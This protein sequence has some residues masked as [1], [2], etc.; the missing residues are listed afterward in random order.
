M[1]RRILFLLLGCLLMTSQIYSQ[2]GVNTEAPNKLTE[3]EVTNLKDAVADTIIPKGVMI[4]RMSE[5]KR[6]VIDVSDPAN[7]NSLMIYNTD[8]DCYNYYSLMDN[9]W[10]SVCGALGKAVI[11]FDCDDITVKGTYVEGQDLTGSNYLQIKVNVVKPGSYTISGTTENG[12]GFFVSG[13]FLAAGE[14]T[15]NAPGQG[16]PVAVQEDVV[17]MNNNGVDMDCTNIIVN[18]MSASGTYTM[19]CYEAQPKGVY[20]V[21]KQLGTSH[22]IDMTLNVTKTGSWEIY[23]DEVDGISFYGSG[24]LAGTGPQPIKLY[25]VEGSIPSST[26]TKTMTLHSNSQGEVV[27]TCTVD[28]IVVIPK[29]KMVTFGLPQ[30]GYSPRPSDPTTPIMQMLFSRNNYG[31]NEDSVVKYEGF[32]AADWIY[33]NN[34]LSSLSATA[35]EDLLMKQRPDIVICGY[36]NNGDFT[37]ERAK[38]FKKYLEAGG[39]V[40]FTTQVAGDIERMMR[41]V[42]NL[43]DMTARGVGGYVYPMSGTDEIMN[44]PFGN[45]SGLNW[46]TDAADAS[47]VLNVPLDQFNIYT[48]GSRIDTGS[49]TATT[50]GESTMFRHKKLHFFY[51]G[52][53]AAYAAVYPYNVDRTIS[54][55]KLDDTTKLPIS[56]PYGTPASLGLVVD[57]AKLFANVFA[58]AIYQAEFNGINTNR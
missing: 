19:N 34:L 33:Q 20:M 38:V 57:N 51:C 4:P 22:Y 6:D 2:V 53:A 37:V 32:D 23:T 16:K 36:Y 8:E 27:K 26:K 40:I 31:P 12:Y 56:K 21:G 39:V 3:L 44:G 49:G 41:T 54:P 55:F 28:V 17:K 50:Y 15:V 43:P 46:G 29:K 14:Q 30:Y 5:A 47:A 11:T 42:F 45:I 9:E 35:L 58:W 18:V 1:G 13:T 48:N 52:E 10:K 25:A 24:E 7:A